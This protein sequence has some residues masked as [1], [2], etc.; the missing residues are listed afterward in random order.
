[1]RPDERIVTQLPLNELWNSRGSLQAERRRWLC[2]EDI[3]QL[4]QSGPLQ[5]VIADAG[6]PLQGIAEERFVFWKLEVRP[7]L[8]DEPERPFDIDTFPE[9]YAYLASQWVF[10]D[11]SASIVLLERYH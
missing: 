9:G 3:R 2:R 1:M 11:S 7:H 10:D 4:L 6:R 8:V 5:F